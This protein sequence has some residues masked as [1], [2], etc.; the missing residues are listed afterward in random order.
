MWQFI[1]RELMF[2]KEIRNQVSQIEFKRIHHHPV[3]L[4][5]LLKSLS[6]EKE[7]DFQKIPKSATKLILK[8][9][10]CLNRPSSTTEN[11]KIK[12]YY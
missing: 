10:T 9:A 8:E 11:L 1:K 2:S 5:V 3:L 12:T 7:N 6:K 4:R